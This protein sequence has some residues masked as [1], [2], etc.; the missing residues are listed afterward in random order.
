[1]VKVTKSVYIEIEKDGQKITFG[2]DEIEDI[3]RQL[4]AAI[5]EKGREFQAKLKAKRKVKALAKVTKVAT[6]YHMSDKK[7]KEIL[8]NVDKKLS[9]TPKTL[10]ALLD[11]VS[12]VPNYLPMIRKMVEGQQNVAKKQVG[13]RTLY[14]L[15]DGKNMQL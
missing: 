6:V 9:G 15:K 12:Y 2:P 1:M 13:K 4:D 7:K 3:K 10:S 8:D 5:R 11:G 14:Y